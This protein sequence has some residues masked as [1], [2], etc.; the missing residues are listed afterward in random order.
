MPDNSRQR[1]ARSPKGFT[2]IEL[3][4][5]IAV[6]AILA[7]LLLPAMQS[8]TLT[9]NKTASLSNMRQLG[10]GFM[11]YAKENDG[12]V[13]QEGESYPTWVSSTQAT[14]S[15]AW[16]NA[17][18]RMAGSLG[19]A[20]Y[21]KHETD[22]YSPKNLT[23]VRAAKYPKTASSAPLFAVS[24]NSKLHDSTLVTND[25]TVRLQNFVN[26]ALTVIFQEAG[27]TGETVIKGQTSSNY[28]GQSKSFASRTAARYNGMTLMVMADGHAESLLATKVVTTAGKAYFPQSQGS[29]Y[30]TMDPTLN[31]NN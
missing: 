23:F 2:L 24:M 12:E 14:Y 20:D 15:T 21:I 25:A 18:P 30:W 4:V 22:F 13:P 28:D 19:L 16:Y 17:V 27:V 8:A 26:P 6:I 5:V 7:A 10:A 29:V 3:L 9:A 31:A 11:N 1:D